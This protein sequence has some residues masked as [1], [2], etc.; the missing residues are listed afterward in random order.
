MQTW[1]IPSHITAT[2]LSAEITSIYLL[3]SLTQH[4]TGKRN[5]KTK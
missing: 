4:N 1:K 3:P 5:S 2:Q